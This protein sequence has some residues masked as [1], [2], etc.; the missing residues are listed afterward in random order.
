MPKAFW[1]YALSAAF[2]CRH[3]VTS[4]QR[5]ACPFELTEKRSPDFSIMRPFG[6]DMYANIAYDERQ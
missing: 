3:Y 4:G 6:C 2:F 1:S 5:S